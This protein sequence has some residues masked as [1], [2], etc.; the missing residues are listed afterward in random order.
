M[1]HVMCDITFGSIHLSACWIADLCYHAWRVSSLELSSRDG[2]MLH[3]CL[4]GDINHADM[5]ILPICWYQKIADRP[6]FLYRYQY[7]SITTFNITCKNSFSMSGNVQ[8]HSQETFVMLDIPLKLVPSI[9]TLSNWVG[10]QKSCILF[11]YFMQFEKA[12]PL[13]QLSKNTI[14]KIWPKPPILVQP[15]RLVTPIVTL[16]NWVSKILYLV[17]IFYAVWKLEHLRKRSMGPRWV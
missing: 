4:Y 15:L 8:L 16:S 3:I 7:R 17:F 10:Y 6:I 2:P 14:R 11:S 12:R 1:N 13:K 5:L 9:V